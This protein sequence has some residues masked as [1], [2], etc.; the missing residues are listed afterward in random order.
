MSFLVIRITRIPLTT[1]TL[2]LL[3]GLID[4]LILGLLAAPILGLTVVL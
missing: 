1:L 2:T 3:L 4:V